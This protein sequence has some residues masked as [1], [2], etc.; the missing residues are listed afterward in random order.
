MRNIILSV[1]GIFLTF[2]LSAA[3]D[4][5]VVK[6]LLCYDS[7]KS[8]YCL[9]EHISKLQVQDIVQQKLIR[10]IKQEIATLKKN[11]I[12]NKQQIKVQQDKIKTQQ[13]EINLQKNKVNAQQKEINLLTNEVNAQQKEINLQ[14]NKVNAQ[15]KEINLLTNEVNNNQTSIKKQANQIEILLKTLD[16]ISLLESRLYRYTDNH[17]GTVTDNRTGL[18]WLKNANCFGNQNWNSAKKKVAKLAS[19]KCGLHDQSK[20]GK[21]RLPSKEE[22]E[23]MMD[24]R[25]R[26]ITLS[27]AMGTDQWKEGDAFLGVQFSKYW[28]STSAK[29]K[30]WYVNIYNGEINSDKH[31]RTLN[32]WPIRSKFVR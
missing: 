2:A 4:E 28:S 20:A 11:Q 1:I 16:R 6:L 26:K 7:P 25:Y 12:Q 14:K 29:K 23:I 22:W 27:N 3:E 31:D 21:W 17:D 30:S 9:A 5:K 19:G 18:V 10:K 32:V 8:D 15:Q 24:Y 13:K